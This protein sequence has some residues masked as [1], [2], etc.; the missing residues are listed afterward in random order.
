VSARRR[1]LK[2]CPG[3]ACIDWMDSGA[4]SAYW[5]KYANRLTPD[6]RKRIVGEGAGKGDYH[7]I[8]RTYRPQFGVGQWLAVG[9]KLEVQ[10]AEI[11]I[12]RGGYK[13]IIGR[14]RDTRREGT[15][16]KAWVRTEDGLEG[17]KEGV[18][19]H[20]LKRFA[21]EA[22]LKRDYRLSEAIKGED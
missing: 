15:P 9:P 4:W 14:V 13:I 1:K 18:D 2:S 12:R 10:V 22:E 20:W 5:K 17:E 21:S 6:E 11:Q 16:I 8:R 7:A 3:Q 19:V